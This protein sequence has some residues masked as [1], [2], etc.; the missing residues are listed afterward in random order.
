[1]QGGEITFRR[2]VQA[3]TSPS[4]VGGSLR[5][6]GLKINELSNPNVVGGNTSSR[7]AQFSSVQGAARV[8]AT[9]V[10]AIAV[11]SVCLVSEP[12]NA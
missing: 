8:S 10:V 5:R 6:L 12:R 11:A 7:R 2:E 4:Q 1:M 9:L 3:M